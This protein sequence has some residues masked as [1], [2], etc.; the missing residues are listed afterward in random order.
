MFK[1]ESNVI[2]NINQIKHIVCLKVIKIRFNSWNLS[3]FRT[4]EALQPSQDCSLPIRRQTP[5]SFLLPSKLPSV[6]V[7]SPLSSAAW[8]LDYT[9]LWALSRMEVILPS[10]ICA[11][12]WGKREDF[13]FD[14]WC[15]RTRSPKLSALCICSFSLSNWM[16][17]HW[18]LHWTV[19]SILN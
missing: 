8:P 19:S 13:K 5:P 17:W 14:C 3:A 16:L 11:R 7:S 9:L 10:A 2:N 12:N 18:C 4:V 15:L 6:G 1:Y